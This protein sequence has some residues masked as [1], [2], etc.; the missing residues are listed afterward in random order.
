MGAT[1]NTPSMSPNTPQGYAPGNNYGSNYSGGLSSSQMG[2]SPSANMPYASNSVGSTS[3]KNAALA[4]N[5]QKKAKKR[6]VFGAILEWL[7]H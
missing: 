7:T 3:G 5:E 1:P 2:N 6:G 4:D